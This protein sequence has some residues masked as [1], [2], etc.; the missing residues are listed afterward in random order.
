MHYKNVVVSKSSLMVLTDIDSECYFGYVIRDSSWWLC[1]G[2][3]G[4]GLLLINVLVCGLVIA[5]DW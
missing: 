2:S 1:I 5:P 3:E 4:F